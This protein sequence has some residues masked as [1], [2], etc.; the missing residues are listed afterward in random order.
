AAG[1]SAS[2][3]WGEGEGARRGAGRDYDHSA[4]EGERGGSRG[5]SEGGS[6]QAPDSPG[7]RAGRGACPDAARSVVPGRATVIRGREE[8]ERRRSAVGGIQALKSSEQ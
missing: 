8:S 2:D 3:R 4:T 1:P 6:G 5:P 7:E